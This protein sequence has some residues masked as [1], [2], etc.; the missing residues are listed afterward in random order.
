MPPSD[1]QATEADFIKMMNAFGPHAIANSAYTKHL[2]ARVDQQSRGEVVM[3]IPFREELTTSAGGGLHNGVITALLDSCGG[4][5][6]AS[7]L[8]KAR[9]IATID[10][11]VDFLREAEPKKDIVGHAECYWLEDELAHMRATAYHDSPDNPVATAAGAFV[12]SSMDNWGSMMD[13]YSE[14]ASRAK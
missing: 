3:R 12:L 4:A 7:R 1:N 14:M 6:I 2:G 10:L 11:R 9:S 5:C 13:R 8:D